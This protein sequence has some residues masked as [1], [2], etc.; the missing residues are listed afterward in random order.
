MTN[1]VHTHKLYIISIACNEHAV[2][3]INGKTNGLCF[4]AS[5]NVYFVVKGP[6]N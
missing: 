2:R 6:K 1:L 4:N 5:F 3:M